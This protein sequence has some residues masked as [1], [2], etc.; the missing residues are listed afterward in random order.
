MDLSI[1]LL[2]WWQGRHVGTDIFGNRYFEEKRPKPGRRQRRWVLYANRA[3]ASQV[4]AQWHGWLHHTFAEFP[5]SYEAKAWQKP[6][7]PNMTGTP[8]AHTPHGP[9]VLHPPLHAEKK[10][11]K[12]YE[13]WEPTP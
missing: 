7:L 5:K 2:T 13:P 8:F 4:P 1:R 9:N 10:S 11:S 12:P 6:H 3:E